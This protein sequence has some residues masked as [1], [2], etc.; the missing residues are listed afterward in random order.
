MYASTYEI[1]NVSLISGSP[2]EDA[3]ASYGL[4]GARGRLVVVLDLWHLKL[5]KMA[6][7]WRLRG[8]KSMRDFIRFR[9][10]A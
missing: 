4:S 7:S 6:V 10:T 5:C 9:G 8:S 1:T 3:T 2:A